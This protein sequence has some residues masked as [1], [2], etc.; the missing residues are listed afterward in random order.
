MEAAKLDEAKLEI[1]EAEPRELYFKM[2][3]LQF[4]PV[5]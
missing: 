2:P 3:L 1:R 4:T 5:V